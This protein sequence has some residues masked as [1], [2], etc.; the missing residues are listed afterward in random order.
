M[1]F[2]L[3]ISSDSSS[4]IIWIN[5]RAL[6]NYNEVNVFLLDELHCQFPGS[7]FSNFVDPTTMPY[8]LQ[9]LDFRPIECVSILKQHFIRKDAHNEVY[10][11]EGKFGLS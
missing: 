1:S 11:R 10:E 6:I 8:K 3:V 7:I 4:V 2:E 9:S 5:G